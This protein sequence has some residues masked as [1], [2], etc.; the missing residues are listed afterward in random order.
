MTEHSEIGGSLLKFF[1]V[2]GAI[3]AIFKGV[4][5]KIH[6]FEPLL[7]EWQSGRMRRS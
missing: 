5:K 7:E 6:T 3:N 1:S 4:L 2:K